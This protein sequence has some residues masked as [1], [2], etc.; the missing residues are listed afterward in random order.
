VATLAGLPLTVGFIGRQVLYQRLVFSPT[1]MLALTIIAETLLISAMLRCLT[2]ADTE[3]V[4]PRGVPAHIG[5]AIALA[6]AA[7]P[8][9][10]PGVIR[11]P[12]IQP[13]ANLDT[14]VWIAWALPLAGAV[15]LTFISIRLGHRVRNW[16]TVAGQIVRLD[17][18]YSMLLPV[19]RAPARAG[20]LVADLLEGEGAFLWMLVILALVLLYVRR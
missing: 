9:M 18:L 12:D 5:Y 1:W 16:G 11:T 13:L 17:W 20:L 3:P 4:M 2:I 6:V 8:L 7:A 14:G 10:V 19:L 15:P